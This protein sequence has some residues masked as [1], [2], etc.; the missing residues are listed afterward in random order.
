VRGLLYAAR[1]QLEQ[2][3]TEFRLAIYSPTSGYTRTNIELAKVLMRLNRPR[4]AAYWADAA[5]RA[6][7]D[8]SQSYATHGELLELGALAWDAAGQADSA[9]TRYKALLYHWRDAEPIF[10]PR[11]ERARLRLE[12]LERR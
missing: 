3:A 8:A 2:A 1:G 10:K 6:G 12:V 4:E 11:V 9:V 7:L 5:R